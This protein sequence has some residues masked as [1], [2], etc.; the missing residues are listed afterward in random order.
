[1]KR[2]AIIFFAIIAIPLNAG[3]LTFIGKVLRQPA[4]VVTYPVRHPLK[5]QKAI[6]TATAKTGKV[7]KKVVW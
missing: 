7:I 2:L 3:V 6:G 1:M 5:S 4:K